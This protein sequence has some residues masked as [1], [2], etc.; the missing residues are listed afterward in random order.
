MAQCHQRVHHHNKMV[1]KEAASKVKASTMTGLPA[2]M[3][4]P[5]S[6]E[7]ATPPTK[8]LT[9]SAPPPH[10]NHKIIDH[11][12]PT[13][14][15]SISPVYSNSKAPQPPQTHQA[16]HQLHN[17]AAPTAH[18]APARSHRTTPLRTPTKTKSTSKATYVARAQTVRS[19][20][21]KS[22]TWPAAIRGTQY[23]VPCQ[24]LVVLTAGQQPNQAPLA[25]P[26]RRL[27]L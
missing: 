4:S 11:L 7:A 20:F 9:S 18:A 21:V 13:T 17:T 8:A 10:N 2:C 27:R 23:R 24:S 12:L 25:H 1:S 14:R 3:A 19:P 6:T 26:I 15:P 16:H 22:S 5:V